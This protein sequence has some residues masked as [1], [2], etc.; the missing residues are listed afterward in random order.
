M[1]FGDF[2]KH[3]KIYSKE[4]RNQLE[5]F[6]LKDQY[7]LVQIL[8]EYKTRTLELERLFTFI[9]LDAVVDLFDQTVFKD[10]LFTVSLAKV[11]KKFLI[12]VNP[13]T[14]SKVRFIENLVTSF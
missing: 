5:E 8:K 7:V 13:D 10:Q 12:S 2:P 1:E 3:M 9:S 4:I 11:L 14:K 6:L